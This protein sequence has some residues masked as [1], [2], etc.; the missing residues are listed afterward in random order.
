MACLAPFSSFE[1]FFKDDLEERALANELLSFFDLVP[2]LVG[3][4]ESFSGFGGTEAGVSGASSSSTCG[5]TLVS[6]TVRAF[7]ELF[8]T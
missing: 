3:S 2:L 5:D 8:E 7:G 1:F 6:L 4:I